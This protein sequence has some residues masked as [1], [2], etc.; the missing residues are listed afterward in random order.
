MDLRPTGNPGLDVMPVHVIV[1]EFAVFI[2]VHDGVRA[3]SDQRHGAG[4]NIDELRQLVNTAGAQ[5][6]AEPRYPGI[7]ALRLPNRAAVFQNRHRAEFVNR[8]LAT[9]EAAAALAKDNRTIGVQLYRHCGQ[10]KQ[11]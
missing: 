1:D 8:E 6:T 7:I 2:I 3:R 10:Q 9:V 4:Q 5:Q 11:R